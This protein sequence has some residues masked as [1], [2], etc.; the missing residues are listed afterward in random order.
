MINEASFTKKIMYESGYLPAGLYEIKVTKNG[1]IPFSRLLSHQHD[2][3][4]RAKHEGLRYKIRDEGFMDER[5]G[6]RMGSQKPADFFVLRNFPAWVVVAFLPAKCW[7]KIDIDD[8][9]HEAE[10][11]PDK[12]L[13]EARASE[14][15]IRV[16][17][18]RPVREVIAQKCFG[19]GKESIR[20]KNHNGDNLC[21][22]CLKKAYE[23]EN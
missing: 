10:T 21:I 14:I 2:S 1:R 20:L 6:K 8:W 9:V 5:T 19:C 12:S 13:T 18:K 3:L 4:L 23:Q 7:Y 16:D 17:I 22:S 15:G 11:S